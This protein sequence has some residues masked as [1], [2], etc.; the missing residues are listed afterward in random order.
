MT[1]YKFFIKLCFI[2]VYSLSELL[3][4]FILCNTA[5]FY[6]TLIR[7]PSTEFLQL[8]GEFPCRYYETQ[9]LGF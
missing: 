4:M 6:F 8:L 1:A 9:A 5:L 7:I 3:T 2:G